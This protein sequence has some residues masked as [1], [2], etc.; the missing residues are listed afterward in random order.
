MNETELLMNSTSTNST[1]QENDL[2]NN[3]HEISENENQDSEEIYD[4]K[5]TRHAKSAVFKDDGDKH[6]LQRSL[7]LYNFT[8]YVYITNFY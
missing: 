7:V 8:L 1:D 2:D 4:D 6:K 3:L 5:V